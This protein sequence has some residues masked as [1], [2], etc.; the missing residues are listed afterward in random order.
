MHGGGWD[1]AE[2]YRDIIKDKEEATA[3]EQ[4]SRMV[5]AEDM[6]TNLIHEQLEKLKS[7]PNNPVVVREL[8]KLYAQ[9]GDYDTALQ[10]FE[11]LTASEGGVDAALEREIGEI[12]AKRVDAAIAAKKE[13]LKQQPANSARLEQE[14]AGL[15]EE[16]RSLRLAETQRLVQRYPNDLMYRF[17]YAVLLMNS[18]Q[19]QEAVEQ[20]QKAVGQPQKRV[21]SLNYLGQCFQEL[22]LHDLAVEQFSKAIAETPSMDN[23]KKDLIYNLGTAYEAM[24]EADKALAEFKKI[25][26]VDYGFRDVREKITRKPA[27]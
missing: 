24:G 15:E 13:E 2:S 1:Q 10:Y 6:V 12:K 23:L 25:A 11:Q 17:D 14:I 22:G 27:G 7:N 21:A 19:I 18:G 5:R 20:F 9:K 4:E 26:A 8:G 16:S 3:L